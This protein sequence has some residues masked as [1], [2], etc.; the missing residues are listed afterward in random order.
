MN[1]DRIVNKIVERLGGQSVL[2]RKLRVSR[3]SV[4]NWPT[5]GIPKR[6]WPIVMSLGYSME[7]VFDIDTKV[8]AK[9]KQ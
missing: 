1:R 5:N 9:K 8:K 6:F 4:Y 7:E 3:Q 2:A